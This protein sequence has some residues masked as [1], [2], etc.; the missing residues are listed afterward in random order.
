[1]PPCSP[2][3]DDGTLGE[4]LV[5]TSGSLPTGG[6]LY[7]GRVVYNI[8]TGSLEVYNG[9][10]W[11]KLQPYQIVTNATRPS[12]TALTTGLMIFET[13]TLR[14]YQY[15]GAAWSL[16]ASLAADETFA[17]TLTQGATPSFTVTRATSRRSGR[18]ISGA[19]TLTL[20]AAT[21][22]TAANV[23][24]V[25]LPAATASSTDILGEGWI[26][27]ASAGFYYY[28]TLVASGGATA[29]FQRRT[30][31]VGV[32]SL[33]SSGFTAALANNDIVKYAFNYEAAAAS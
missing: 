33:G 27:D 1:M 14:T 23:V 28:G 11:V 22:G 12:G 4:V 15:T 24:I 13:D 2:Y 20:T 17:A 8:S 25:G 29:F 30:D 16:I 3:I 10:A 31:G 32:T 18:H 9:T 26:Y 21:P 6:D 19:V 5:V 7:T